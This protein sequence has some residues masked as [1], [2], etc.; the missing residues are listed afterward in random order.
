MFMALFF[1]IGLVLTIGPWALHFRGDLP[2]TSA[3]MASGLG[4]LTLVIV[5]AIVIFTRLYRRAAANLAF[6]RTGS[7]G[8]KVIKDSGKIVVPVMHQVIPVSLETMRLNVERRGAHALI[9][10]DNLRV[11]LS[12][13]FYIKVQANDEDILQAARSLGGRSVQP[14]AVSELVQ[15]KLVSALRTVAATKDLHELHSKRDEF[16]TSVQQIVTHDLAS[17]GLSLESVTIS[18]LDQTDP[19]AL[20]ERNVFDAQ[21]LRKIAEITQIA[22]AQRN[23]IEREAEQRI[24]AKN[25]ATRKQVLSLARD[26]AEAE[27]EQKMNIANVNAAREREIAEFKIQQ[28]EAVAKREIEKQRQVQAAE[29]SRRLAIEQAEIEKQTALVAKTREQQQA[30]ILKQQAIE[31]AD[32]QREAAVAEKETEA[33]QARAAMLAAEAEREKAQQAVVTVQVVAEADRE[34][35][36]KLT[37][38]RQV[39]SEN[40][41]KEETNADVLA[42]MRIKEAD[43]QRQAAEMTYAAKLRLA[44]AESAS[45]TKR[46]EGERSIKMVDVNVERERVNVEQARVEV[47]RVSLSNK[48]EFEEAALKFELD[49][50]R[51]QA[52]KE[53]RIAAAQA[54]ANMFAKAQ[55]QIFGD[56]STMASMSQQFMK[57]AGYG[58]TADGLLATLPAEAKTLLASLGQTVV[59]Q[60]SAQPAA[61]TNGQE[62][63]LE[64]VGAAAD[65]LHRG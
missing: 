51:I 3:L 1:A 54:M 31:V 28:D 10:R 17:N 27:A 38:A 35:Q 42:Y 52:D 37:A 32:R 46:A 58:N 36:K 44:E 21:G 63:P 5:S 26:Q 40:K 41:I 12:A 50:L 4:V 20:Q 14:D 7:G 16:A 53:V 33:V 15:E 2:L 19:S 48:Q 59:S 49:K 22:R 43:A 60:M 45:A 65:E 39:A 6:V 64:T 30:E 62:R 55:M 24:A 23:E 13:E 18:S 47:E 11:D 57:A 8:A 25:V 29:V 61:E 34:A 56:P 9:T